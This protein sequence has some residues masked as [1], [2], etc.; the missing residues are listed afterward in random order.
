MSSLIVRHGSGMARSV[1]RVAA[2][3]GAGALAC[4]TL[5]SSA[6][7]QT[8][9]IDPTLLQAAVV[10]VSTEGVLCPEGS[11]GFGFSEAGVTAVLSE[12]VDGVQTAGCKL[13]V[14]LEVPEGLS[15]GMPTTI[16]RGF[17]VDGVR[18]ES[19]YAFEGAGA[20]GAFIAQPL[21]DFTIQ[22]ND[23]SLRSRSC[24]GNRRVRY[25]VDVTAQLL[26]ATTFFQLDSI[27]VETSWRF[28]TDWQFCD[29]N[30]TLQVTP[31]EDGDFCDGA[32]G[33]PCANGLVCEH[34]VPN[35]SEGSC[36]AP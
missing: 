32:N 20:S 34:N 1:A 25:S 10:Q 14:E 31:G 3:A 6:F 17:T 12:S 16:L 7:A 15:L 28:G 26:S 33:R 29:P 18:L 5:S 30:Q 22:D 23:A 13:T 4:A 27:D 11:V 2:H 36:A 24:E 21:E 9:L 35:T 8:T 19:R